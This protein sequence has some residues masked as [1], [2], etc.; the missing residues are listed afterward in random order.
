MSPNANEVVQRILSVRSD[1]DREEVWRRIREKKR[2]AGGYLTDEAAARIVASELGL[3]IL[4]E[5]LP[6]VV[7]IR[8]L[9]SGLG[10]ATVMGRVI[11]VYP[12]RSFSRPDS[13]EGSVSSLLIAD[14]T[15]TL[16]VVLWGDKANLVKEGIE[17]GKIVKVLHGYVREGRDGRTELHA[18]SFSEVQVS[19]PDAMESEYP[20]VTSFMT[21]IGELRKE[22]KRANVVG[23]VQ[24]VYPASEF[25]RRNGTRGKVMR[26]RLMDNTGQVTVTL[27]NEKV[28]ELGGVKKGE[29]L[30]IMNAKVRERIDG[31]LELHAESHTQIEALKEASFLPSLMQLAKIGD[32]VPGMRS[33]NVLARI[34]H[35]GEVREF[36]R[37]NKETGQVST[38]M[39]KDDSGSIRVNLWGGKALMV[40]KVLP[41]DVILIEQAYT[42]ERFE[43]MDL[44]VGEQGIVTLNPPLAEA[45]LLPTHEEKTTR[46]AEIK[47]EGG[48]ITVEGTVVTAQVVKEVTTTRGEK[49]K[50]ASF[51]ISDDDEIIWISFWRKMAEAAENLAVGNRIKVRNVYVKKNFSGQLELTSRA[52][53]SIEVLRGSRDTR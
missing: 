23:V 2:S 38:L 44:N 40:Q 52:L 31:E 28:D 47:G 7:A 37:S 43:K 42:R 6:S 46:L 35:V 48:P 8:D 34:I 25:E 5:P 13:S 50:M 17:Q 18:G 20:Q 53:T 14:R 49:V 24:R 16:R 33:V 30:Q 15:R 32:L 11:I 12:M 22:S 4:R 45:E 27:W 10:D 1:L 26:L 19:P 51:Q 29:Y 36:K 41:G 39:I 9:V 21:K 3:E